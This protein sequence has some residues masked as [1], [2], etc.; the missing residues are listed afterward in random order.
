V[1]IYLFII[2][3]LLI[4]NIASDDISSLKK[5]YSRQNPVHGRW[6]LFLEAR[7]IPFLFI[8]LLTV[9]FTLIDYLSKPSWPLNPLLSLLN[10]R[11]SNQV[12]YCLILLFVLK[13][14]HRPLVSLPLFFVFCSV[15]FLLDYNFYEIIPVGRV[16]PPIK[17]S[18]LRW[19]RILSSGNSMYS[20]NESAT[21]FLPRRECL[22]QSFSGYRVL[23]GGVG[24]W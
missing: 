22:W 7:V 8:Y 10:G 16:S 15:Y 3:F 17:S 23:S 21:R 5:E 6:L 19:S 14:R 20:A 1:R 24:L 4:F 13:I 9:V 2:S 18:R 12:I 11:Y